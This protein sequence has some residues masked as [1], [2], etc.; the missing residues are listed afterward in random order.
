M[1]IKYTHEMIT[2]IYESSIFRVVVARG[3]QKSETV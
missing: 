2:M 3:K 1:S